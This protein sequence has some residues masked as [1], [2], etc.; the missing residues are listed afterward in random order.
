MIELSKIDGFSFDYDDGDYSYTSYLLEI[1]A[2]LFWWDDLKQ[3]DSRIKY[4]TVY[5]DIVNTELNPEY[6]EGVLYDKEF[7]IDDF[8]T[9]E[10]EEESKRILSKTIAKLN[11]K[12]KCI[13][14]SRDDF[15]THYAKTMELRQIISLLPMS[16]NVTKLIMIDK[17]TILDMCNENRDSNILEWRNFCDIVRKDL[18]SYVWG[19][20]KYV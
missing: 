1:K 10:L 13:L 17:D 5:N 7:S 8:S 20:N 15:I 2:P 18:L 4:I 19:V 6:G 9:E 12:R 3:Y 14:G 16:Y 11:R